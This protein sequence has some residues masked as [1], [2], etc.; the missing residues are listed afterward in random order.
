MGG[1]SKSKTSSSSS[2]A[3]KALLTQQ[4]AAILTFLKENEMTK[5][6]DKLR[7]QLEKDGFKYAKNAELDGH[8]KWVEEEEEESSSEEEDSDSS[9]D[10][11]SETEEESSEEEEESEEE[12]S[13]EEESVSKKSSGK[14]ISR[15]KSDDTP[16]KPPSDTAA[17]E[18]PSV[19]AKKK[20][21]GR[22]VSFSD[23]VQERI[24][25]P[26]KDKELR[27]K[28]FFSKAELRQIKM[29][30][31]EEKLNEQMAA[32]SAAFGITLPGL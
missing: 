16:L 14:N 25:S 12:E 9:S 32:A 19:G 4:T 24:L 22:S 20:G 13:E 27:K 26:C 6:A 28:L 17:D 21:F 11:E 2:K 1:S 7:K 31:Q 5:A 30:A 29:E 8:W 23:E 15:T 3:K 18:A 10:E